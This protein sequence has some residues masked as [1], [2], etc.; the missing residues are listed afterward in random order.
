MIDPK[1]LKDADKDI[2]PGGY[3]QFEAPIKDFVKFGDS[4]LISLTNG[5][6][7]VSSDGTRFYEA[8][9]TVSKVQA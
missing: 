7:Y 8:T 5:K 2:G 6:I 1:V 3:V 9:L 4:L